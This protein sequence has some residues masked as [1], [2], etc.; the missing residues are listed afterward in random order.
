MKTINVA[1]QRPKQGHQCTPKLQGVQDY[2]A[3]WDLCPTATP[4]GS[5]YNNS[6]AGLSSQSLSMANMV[7]SEL[8]NHKGL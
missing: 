6:T 5:K 2:K 1:S 4:Y 7:G 8:G 3:V